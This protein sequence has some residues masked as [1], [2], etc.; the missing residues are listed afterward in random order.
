MKNLIA[1]LYKL[2]RRAAAIPPPNQLEMIVAVP[3]GTDAAENRP[4]GVYYNVDKTVADV[5]FSGE[6]PPPELMAE[7]KG[8]LSPHGL[9][10]VSHRSAMHIPPPPMPPP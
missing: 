4:D 1:R 7:L 5:V 10:I 6:E 8:R 2:E 3:T 9:L